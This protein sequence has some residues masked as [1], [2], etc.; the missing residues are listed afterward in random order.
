MEEEAWIKI[1]KELNTN[2]SANDSPNIA[3]C[4]KSRICGV[5]HNSTVIQ[6]KAAAISGCSLSLPRLMLNTDMKNAVMKPIKYR[7]MN[8]NAVMILY[9]LVNK[10]YYII[11]ILK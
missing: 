11:L 10:V 1:E 6:L 2:D 9:V 3:P 8:N 4:K 7:P 5:I